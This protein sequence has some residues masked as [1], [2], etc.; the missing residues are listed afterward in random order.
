[1]TRYHQHIL[2]SFMLACHR[3]PAEVRQ[4]KSILVLY[5]NKV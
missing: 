4:H 5:W 1:M 3:S 2:D